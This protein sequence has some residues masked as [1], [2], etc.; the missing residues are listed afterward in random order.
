M[1]SSAGEAAYVKWGL[2]MTGA[3]A[4]RTAALCRSVAASCPPA[5]AH[6]TPLPRGFGHPAEAARRRHH[7]GA[8]APRHRAV[9]TTGS[10]NGGA[11]VAGR[12]PPLA[13]GGRGDQGRRG[14]SRDVQREKPCSTPSPGGSSGTPPPPP[15]PPSPPRTLLT[16]RASALA[17]SPTT[18]VAPPHGANIRALALHPSHGGGRFLLSASLDGGVAVYDLAAPPATAAAAAA[19]A[20]A[21]GADDSGGWALGDGA[22]THPPV[23]V[24]VNLGLPPPAGVASAAAT[25]AAA[26]AARGPPRRLRQGRGAAGARRPTASLPRHYAAGTARR[27]GAA[28][29][30]AASAAAAAAAATPDAPVAVA[31]AAWYPPDAGLF[32]TADDGG[33]VKAWDT[34]SLVPAAA[35]RTPA[36]ARGV[37]LSRAPGG[38]PDVVAVAGAGGGGVGELLLVDLGAGAVAAALGGEGGDRPADGAGGGCGGG[39]PR[40]APGLAAVAWS[41][42][43]PHLVAAASAAGGVVRLFDVRR[44]G[45]SAVVGV[46]DG[47]RVAVGLGGGGVAAAATV[48]AGD[49]AT[50]NDGWAVD[51]APLG[52]GATVGEAPTGGGARRKRRRRLSGGGG[53]GRPVADAAGV[54][55]VAWSPDGR[56]VWTRGG[57]G[58]AKWDALTAHRVPAAAGWARLGGGTAGGTGGRGGMVPAADGET[59][60]VAAG[61]SVAVVDGPTGARVGVL[62]GHWGRVTALAG[63][64]GRPSCR[65]GKTCGWLCGSPQRRGGGG[66]EGGRGGGGGRPARRGGGDPHDWDGRDWGG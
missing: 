36:P 35:V 33:V 4:C 24:T 37:A 57:G 26:A 2:G 15:P 11:A 40:G 48:A 49:G 32:V 43:H 1:T 13:T 9:P 39:P 7:R 53:A 46:L 56:W 22:P 5:G 8:A 41:P 19:A 45:D 28:A 17:P 52:V 58:V 16:L 65:G 14:R 66:G 20:A 10:V 29:V 38:R 44:S 12:P 54:A 64:G 60:F 42:V 61:R 51:A 6:A 30:D 27:H 18:R 25:A 63:G 62:D 31:A 59:L 3:R 34:A 23:G 21:I 55:D 50:D 47:R